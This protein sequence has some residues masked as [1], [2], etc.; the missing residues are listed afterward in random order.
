MLFLSL[1]GILPMQ[2]AFCIVF[3]S[4][5]LGQTS[6][7]QKEGCSCS[8]TWGRGRSALKSLLC[9]FMGFVAWFLKISKV[10]RV[11]LSVC[12]PTQLSVNLLANFVLTCLGA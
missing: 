11:M 10:C 12:L 3:S 8:Q 9:S 1:L 7:Y 2:T 6:L 4:F 5:P